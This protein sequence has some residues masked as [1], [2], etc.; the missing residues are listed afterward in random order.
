MTTKHPNDTPTRI[1]RNNGKASLTMNLSPEDCSEIR[2]SPIYKGRLSYIKEILLDTIPN[3]DDEI[4]SE[5]LDIPREVA[6]LL[7]FDC[8]NSCEDEEG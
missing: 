4:L 2:K 6:Q 3:I 8:N 1:D 7:L 5:R